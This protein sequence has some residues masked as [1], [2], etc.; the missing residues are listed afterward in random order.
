MR[1]AVFEGG[2]RVTV[3]E[4][5]DPTVRRPD[6]VV[7]QVA[8]NGL[9]GSDLRA[10]AVPPE[11]HYDEGVIIGHEFSGTVLEAGPEADVAVGAHVIVHPN[12]WC[13]TCK[14]CRSG[15]TNLCERFVHI[16]SMRD[17]GAAEYCVVPDRMIYEVSPQMPSDLASLAEPL[18]CVLNGSKRAGVHPGESAL[19][20][21][22]GPIGL[23]YLMLLK[24]AGAEPLIV[25]EPSANR[26]ARARELGA[27]L[28]VDPTASDVGDEARRAT[29][30]SVSTW[31]STRSGR[32]SRMRSGPCAR[33]AACSCSAST[34]GRRPRCRR[35]ISPTGKSRFR[36][37]TSHEA[38]S[39]SRSG[40][41]RRTRFAST[42]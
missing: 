18:A 11:M 26:A 21:G 36:A 24:A 13:Q 33:R 37:C 19:V 23:L 42:G 39:R 40:C 8:A 17:G 25:S 4:R 34:T 1:A 12:I 2:G 31:P 32:C 30:G 7:I 10:L 22:A 16:G 35:P 9:C 41:S 29:G 14:Y 6:D 38:R 27:D 28:I 15:R 20:I 5:P 3:G